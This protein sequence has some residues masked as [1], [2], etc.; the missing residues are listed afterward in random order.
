MS[1]ALVTAVLAGM[2][3][4]ANAPLAS[5]AVQSPSSQSAAKGMANPAGVR[6]P[7][8]LNA[9]SHSVSGRALSGHHEAA[10][11]YFY[12]LRDPQPAG[13]KRNAP[14]PRTTTLRAATAATAGAG[15]PTWTS[16]GPSPAVGAQIP[17]GGNVSGRVYAVVPDPTDASGSIIY[18]AAASGGVWKTTDKG[19]SWM[20]LTDFQDSLATTE[21]VLDPTNTQQIYAS[22]GD[23]TTSNAA[24]GSPS[25]R[26]CTGLPNSGYF[27][28]GILTSSDGGAHWTTIGAD[29]FTGNAIYDIDISPDG[30]RLYIATTIGFWVGTKG[31]T[32]GWTFNQRGT[33]CYWS[34]VRVNP[35]NPDIVNIGAAGGPWVY[36][37]AANTLTP[38]TFCASPTDCITPTPFQP[39][40]V[41]RTTIA[42]DRPTP[43]Y[44][45]ASMACDVASGACPNDGASPPAPY[46]WWGVFESTDSGT[47][48]H[49]LIIPGTGWG[50]PYEYSQTSYDL[51]L[52]VDPLDDRF[53]YFGLVDL[54]LYS[55]VSS[56]A[57]FISAPSGSPTFPPCSPYQTSRFNLS[58][59]IHCDQHAIG[60]DQS[61]TLYVG[62]DGGVFSSPPGSHGGEWANRNSNLT[63]SQ[64]YPGIGYS[65]ASPSR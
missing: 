32:G 43:N 35:G 27:G 19:A 47:S 8:G 11:A 54:F 1:L 31:A 34:S 53:I 59:G 49:P 5:A 37:V 33:G 39:V 29:K 48:F 18:A 15:G 9:G 28:A 14:I 16:I 65:P 46:R 56:T 17:G 55:Y 23:P 44:V 61:G 13:S 52:G 62:N 51:D 2:D 25:T 24:Y 7:F 50:P 12:A 26:T 10:D 22:T 41:G 38:S 36:R 57:T 20:P 60:F 3:S 63:I 4:V 45:Y 42:V 64:F 30:K 40:N 6:G 21:I 58:P